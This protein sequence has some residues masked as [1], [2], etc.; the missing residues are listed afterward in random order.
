MVFPW[1]TA[2]RDWGLLALRVAVGIIFIVHGQAKFGLLAGT[3]QALAQGNTLGAILGP[4]GI[5]EV[6]GGFALIL[7]LASQVVCLF[8][9]VDMLGA[10]M[11]KNL[12]MATG[13]MGRN[14]TGWEFDFALLAANIALLL[15]GPGRFALFP[16]G[17][18]DRGL[19]PSA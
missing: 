9:S 6:I 18:L 11:V 4:I 17:R 3:S 14:T 12:M 7:G 2:Y 8:F 10:I 15:V 1:L 5:L 19:A 13:F 16:R